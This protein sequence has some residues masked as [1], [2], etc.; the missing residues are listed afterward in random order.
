MFGVFSLI[1]SIMG[2]ATKVTIENRY[3]AIVYSLVTSNIYPV[4]TGPII[5]DS[6]APIWSIPLKEPRDRVPYSFESKAGRSDTPAPKDTP[7]RKVKGIVVSSRV[8]LKAVKNTQPPVFIIVTAIKT[9]RNGNKSVRA[10]APNLPIPLNK[11]TNVTVRAASD[12][13]NPKCS[14]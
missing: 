10:P 5:P 2:K 11:S 8:V 7:N 13:L 6:K 14:K 9:T 12:V 3:R 4:A 1:S